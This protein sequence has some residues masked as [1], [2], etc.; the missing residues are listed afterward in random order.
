MSSLAFFAGGM[1]F[2]IYNISCPPGPQD[3][4]VANKGLKVGIPDPKKVSSHH[5]GGYSYCSTGCGGGVDPMDT[6]V[7][8]LPK[9]DTE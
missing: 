7:K 1:F 3:A 2:I 5:P 4:I 8:E 9:K 6:G